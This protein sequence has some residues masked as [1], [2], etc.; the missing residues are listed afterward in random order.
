MTQTSISLQNSPTRDLTFFCMECNGT[1][2]QPASP[3]CGQS[4][5]YGVRNVMCSISGRSLLAGLFM[6]GPAVCIRPWWLA[7]VVLTHLAYHLF[8]PCAQLGAN[9]INA[10]S[11]HGQ[12]TVNTRSTHGQ[13][14]VNIRSTSSKY[15]KILPF[16]TKAVGGSCFSF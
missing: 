13:H 2:T 15:K 7:E 5:A 1:A 3:L 14:A 4:M 11:T 9:T 6:I 16:P 8:P 10:R 12:H